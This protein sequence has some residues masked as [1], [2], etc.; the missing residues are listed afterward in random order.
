[1]SKLKTFVP[2][3][4]QAVL[5]SLPP[6]SY[7]HGIALRMETPLNGRKPLPIGV[8]IIWDNDKIQTGRTFPVEY[9]LSNLLP[10][11]ADND[12]VLL[13]TSRRGGRNKAQA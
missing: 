1:M 9:P 10:P 5:N 7:I 2:V 13:A 4:V 6:K 12:K 3:D 8:E 11:P